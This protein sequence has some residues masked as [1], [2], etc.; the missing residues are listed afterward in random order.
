MD[1]EMHF[2]CVGNAVGNSGN[3]EKIS[4]FEDMVSSGNEE[5]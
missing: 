5:R 1:S 3:F 4:A 2:S